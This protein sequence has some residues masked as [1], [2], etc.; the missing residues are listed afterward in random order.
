MQSKHLK[1][2]ATAALVLGGVGYLMA[3]SLEETKAYYKHVNEVVG[4]TDKWMDKDLQVHGFVEVKSVKRRIE[5][6]KQ[7]V[8]FVLENNGEKIVV[9]TDGR[10]VIPDTFKD[11]A[12]VVA[13]GRLVKGADGQVY[14]LAEEISAKCPSKYEE[15]K[16]AKSLSAGRS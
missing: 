12:E 3:S 2:I 5:N 10:A 11:S 7:K 9:K 6:H 8:D 15:N 1:I 13:K 14:L 4:S 16:R